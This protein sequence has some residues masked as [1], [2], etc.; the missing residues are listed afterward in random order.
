[1]PLGAGL[2]SQGGTEHMSLTLFLVLWAC[3]AFAAIGLALY[4]KLLAR[5]EDD[6]IHVGEGTDKMVQQQTAL[7][8]R[9]EVI[10]RWEKILIIVIHG[11]SAYASSQ[12]AR[13]TGS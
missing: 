9:L 12:S 11:L 8:Q 7:A 2:T 3:V 4:R 6:Y 1:M 5:N 13:P 10:D